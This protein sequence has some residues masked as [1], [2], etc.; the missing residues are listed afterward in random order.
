M[1]QVDVVYGFWQA[2][3]DQHD[4]IHLIDEK[5]EAIAKSYIEATDIKIKGSE[6]KKYSIE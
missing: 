3:S 1:I 2:Y 6:S 4:D 5:G